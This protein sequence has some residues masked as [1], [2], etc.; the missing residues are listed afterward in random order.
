MC[1]RTEFGEC[2]TGGLDEEWRSDPPV[3]RLANMCLVLVIG[4]LVGVEEEGVVADTRGSTANLLGPCRCDT[5]GFPSKAI[6]LSNCSI[7]S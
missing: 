3:F 5:G 4:S 6:P 2:V 1:A 7:I